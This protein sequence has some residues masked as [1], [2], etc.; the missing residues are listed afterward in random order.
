MEL[1]SAL[2][3]NLPAIVAALPPALDGELIAPGAS[4]I[5]VIARPHAFRME[6]I[7]STCRA[8]QSLIRIVYDALGGDVTLMRR[9]YVE[10]DGVPF[11]RE[12]WHYIRPK[13][14]TL[15]NVVVVPGFGGSSGGGKNPLRII[16]SLVLV[17]ASFVIGGW[18]GPLIA[19]SFGYAAAGSAA[20]FFTAAVSG[21][22]PLSGRLLI[23]ATAPPR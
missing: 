20:S 17:A 18:A 16:L 22:V 23:N 19:T 11:K 14:G 5:R 4:D 3:N 10:I 6:R 12:C 13:P 7:E 21:A 15:I 1:Q 9:A 2:P 8:G